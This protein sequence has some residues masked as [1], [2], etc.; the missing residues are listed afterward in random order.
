MEVSF[1]VFRSNINSW[2][3]LFIQAANF[4]TSI[5]REK[6]ISISHSCDNNDAVVSVWYWTKRKET[7]ILGIGELE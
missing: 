6:V 1:E 5:G 3:N 7:N 2:N 4:A